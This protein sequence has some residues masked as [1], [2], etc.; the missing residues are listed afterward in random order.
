MDINSS[1]II[2]TKYL[3]D[4]F[5]KCDEIRLIFP[6]FEARKIQTL[7][8]NFR[9]IRRQSPNRFISLYYE[10]VAYWYAVYQV[11]YQ[12]KFPQIEYVIEFYLFNMKTIKVTKEKVG[13]HSGVYIFTK[14]IPNKY[15]K[16]NRIKELR[17]E[18]E[19]RFPSFSGEWSHWKITGDNALLE[20]V[21]GVDLFRA[22]DITE[23]N[24]ERFNSI[25]AVRVTLD[26]SG[27][28]EREEKHKS[29]IVN[30]LYINPS[31][32]DLGH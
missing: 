7:M 16:K 5:N 17:R 4:E 30:S 24:F 1:E 25:K 20:V 6:I 15:N 29:E 32:S 12:N 10:L 21:S 22:L 23:E 31:Q 28:I 9:K 27:N 14:I 19:E 18:W 13:T 26:S 11:Y 8:L 2:S 3:E